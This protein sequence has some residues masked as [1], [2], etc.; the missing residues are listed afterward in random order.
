[1]EGDSEVV[2]TTVEYHFSSAISPCKV[3]VKIYVWLC[4]LFFPETAT[5]SKC[6]VL[7]DVFNVNYINV[8]PIADSLNNGEKLIICWPPPMALVWSH[9]NRH[10]FQNESI[11]CT[12]YFKDKLFQK[13]YTLNIHCLNREKCFNTIWHGPWSRFAKQKCVFWAQN[14]TR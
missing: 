12:A 3:C 1:M 4:V 5:D 7:N 9:I 14:Y 11:I 6:T 2:L 10:C 8:C 13:S